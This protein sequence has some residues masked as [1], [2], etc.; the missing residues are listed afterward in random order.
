MMVRERASTRGTKAPRTSRTSTPK[1]GRTLEP[2]VRGHFEP[3]FGTDLSKIRVHRDS[4]T[5]EKHDARAVS[6]GNDLHFARGEYS[7]QSSEGQSVIA[8]ELSHSLQQTRGGSPTA[9]V[10]TLEDEASSMS[11]QV[12]DG[13]PV[14]VSNLSSASP[15][16]PL[17]LRRGKAA[18][19][20]RAGLPTA[21]I[22]ESVKKRLRKRKTV[23]DGEIAQQLGALRPD[24]RR[25]VAKQVEAEAT[26]EQRE[27]Y[28]LDSPEKRPSPPA[29]SIPEPK[30]LP[31]VSEDKIE[32]PAAVPEQPTERT[33]EVSDERTDALPAAEERADPA[34]ARG[35]AATVTPSQAPAAEP[36]VEDAT[37]S[38]TEAGPA[39]EADVAPAPGPDDNP[40]FQELMQGI[41]SRATD[42]SAH[43][44]APAAAAAAQHAAISPPNE[45]E[46]RAQA[47]Q[48]DDMAQQ[49]TNPFDKAA[50]KAALLEKVEAITPSNLEEADEFKDSGRAGELREHVSGEVTT[51]REQAAGA[52]P[53][54]AAAEPDTAAIPER[55][56][57]PLVAD[58]V[59]AAPS[60]PTTSATGPPPRSDAEVSLDAGPMS[61][62]AEMEQAGVT[63]EQLAQSNEPTFNEALGARQ[64]AQDHSEAAPAQFRAEEQATIAANEQEAATGVSSGLQGMHSSRSMGL[65]EASG[66]QSATRTRDEAERTRISGEINTMFDTTKTAV[67][68]RL[69]R[70]DTESGT[71]FDTGAEKARTNFE[72]Y[73]DAR[74]KA[75]KDER[76]SGWL[77]GTG[78]WIA[79]KL[80]GLPSEVNVFY[81]E[82]KRRY[83]Q[84]MDGVIDQVATI[85]ETGLT[86]AKTLVETGRLQIQVYVTALPDNLRKFGEEAEEGL[87]SQFD[88]LEQSVDDKRDSLVDT[89]AQRYVDS[90]EAVD[91]RMAEM[92]EANKGLVDKAIGFV[93]GVINTII[94][95]KNM[96]LSVLGKAASVIGKIIRDPIGFLGNL[97][98]AVGQGLSQF[99]ENIGK[100][101]LN[102][103]MGWLFGALSAAGLTMPEKF[104][105]KGIL[106]I[107]LQVLGLTYQNIRSRAV[108]ILGERIVGALETTA[109]VFMVLIREGPAGLWRWIKDQFN[110]LKDTVMDGIK[111]MVAEKIVKAGITW[112]LGMLNPAGAFIKACMLIKDVVMFFVERGRQIY[113][114]VNAII[115]SVSAIADGKLEQAAN[116][117]ENAM[118]KSV[119]V[120][121]SFLASL[122]GLGGISDKI[123]SI[124]ERIQ[125]PI[126]KIIDAVIKGAVKAVM[127]IGRA[128]GGRKTE[129]DESDEGSEARAL[130]TAKINERL[131]TE[132]SLEDIQNI[133]GEIEHDLKPHGIKSLT[134]G[135]QEDGEVEILA[136]ASKKKSAGK[137]PLT[138]GEDD[139]IVEM[140]TALTLQKSED[141]PADLRKV[142]GG[143]FTR[144]L[145]K[146]DLREEGEGLAIGKSKVGEVHF[147]IAGSPEFQVTTWNSGKIKI[148]KKTVTTNESHA[149]WIFTKY[150]S[151]RPD[152][153]RQLTEIKIVITHSPCSCCVSTLAGLIDSINEEKDKNPGSPKLKKA[154]LT[155]TQL[156]KRKSEPCPGTKD[157]SEMRGKEFT[158]KK[159]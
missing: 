107:V 154:S 11:A 53:A 156:Y 112:L 72:T 22:G 153:V 32:P 85:V 14:S 47:A 118:A 122:L 88:Q 35:R 155:Y 96:L 16:T 129:A 84:E 73:T 37:P 24:V 104:D 149:E 91:A 51:G 17:F 2:D 41:S 98:S 151:R 114:L 145:K 90:M 101:L 126:N 68:N 103:L 132:H 27:S 70:L 143:R 75:Y 141:V 18:A 21:D 159:R 157:F 97:I 86:E 78:R 26:P 113:E 55:E 36:V 65:G 33:A 95:I 99:V 144:R 3:L 46:S 147:A 137:A 117:V 139:A 116:W 148:G 60:V 121:I 158:V 133:V 39:A 50:F 100:H 19:K 56:T 28:A 66:R 1:T 93:V 34:A 64:E 136:E 54:A 115:D 67:E 77:T 138:P 80:L 81:E 4:S 142:P 89:L 125:A 134:V 12:S 20:R 7:P 127:A 25:E 8:H 10:G 83:I 74:M 123:R 94:E 71:A 62:D 45:R 58:E 6:L 5:A 59:G 92:K 79:D 102:G 63:T 52:L 42:L 140:N 111:A 31:P 44:P 128:F 38:T 152:I 13:I 130:A 106:S 109:E 135:E 150:L 131:S 110:T 15:T 69:A 119:P 23:D 30:P 146:D 61:V 105:L 124:I 120:I 87:A 82:G 108:R 9:G 57:E 43:T 76:Y 29:R 49:E 40:E 48:T